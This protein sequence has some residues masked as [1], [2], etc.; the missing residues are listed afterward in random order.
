MAI[1]KKHLLFSVVILLLGFLLASSLPAE[2]DRRPPTRPPTQPP[3]RPPTQPPTRPPSPP[4]PRPPP[5]RPPPPPPRRP[6]PPPPPSPP[7]PR[8]PPPP[9]P[10]SPPP[11]RRPPPPPPPSPPPPSPPPPTPSPP[12]PP[13]RPINPPGFNYFLLVLQWPNAYCS[14]RGTCNPPVPK[15]HF[16]IRG[17]RPQRDFGLLPPVYCDTEERMTDDILD[18]LRGDLLEYWPRLENADNFFTSKFLWIDQ[19]ITYG[20]CSSNRFPPDAYLET[21][22]ALAKDHGPLIMDEMAHRGIEPDGSTLHT[23][24]EVLEAIK[25]ATNTEALITCSKDESGRLQLETIRLCVNVNGETLLNC[26]SSSP[27]GNCEEEF[28]FPSPPT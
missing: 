12:P 24:E 2:E 7:P 4:P 16:T 3:T 27:Q 14:S 6:P 23:A 1:S 18:E 15:Q 13:P 19:W 20:S 26:L 17:L 11:P 22:I 28:I 9:P 21:A 8:R 25:A 10:P 5:P